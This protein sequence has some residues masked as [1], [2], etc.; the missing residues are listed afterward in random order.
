M[1]SLYW[2]CFVAGGVF[3]ALA[4]VSGLDG[5]EIDGG[6]DFDFHADADLGLEQGINADLDISDPQP[7]AK[8]NRW[9]PSTRRAAKGFWLPWTSFKF[10]TFGTCFFGLT[11]LLLS[12]LAPTLSSS[13]ILV[14]AIAMGLFCGTTMATTLRFL[15]G[16]RANS[17]I[18]TSDLIGQ[19]GSVELPFDPESRGKVRLNLRGVS[20]AFTAHTEEQQAFAIDDRAVI[21][22]VDG[23]NVWVVS[24][25][26]FEA[27][28]LN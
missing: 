2:I 19:V 16:R 20:V 18:E 9:L 17:L 13:G 28:K 1:M 23:S 12:Q 22:N 26:T 4:A 25:A 24:E 6:L 11:G 5:V 14:F 10:W 3:V 21:V 7:K 27:T 8:Q 15:R